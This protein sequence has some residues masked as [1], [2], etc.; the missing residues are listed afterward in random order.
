[1]R[2]TDLY[3]VGDVGTGDDG[4]II[5]VP[6]LNEICAFVEILVMNHSLLD[7]LL[8]YKIFIFGNY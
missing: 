4:S 7:E 5:S 6:G 3:F 8:N 1:M 2:I